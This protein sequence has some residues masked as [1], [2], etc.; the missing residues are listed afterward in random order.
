MSTEHSTG[1]PAVAVG[2]Y[3]AKESTQS[4]LVLNAEGDA[5]ATVFIRNL[6]ALS[7]GEGLDA[8]NERCRAAALAQAHLLA[9]SWDLLAAC[10]AC[11]EN[12]R[13]IH[14][15]LGEVPE[16]SPMPK[17]CTFEAWKMAAEAIARACGLHPCDDPA[18][19]TEVLQTQPQCI[20]GEKVTSAVLR[21]LAE[22]I[23]LRLRHLLP[24]PNNFG[25]SIVPATKLRRSS[26]VR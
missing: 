26:A 12:L 15:A 5:L 18:L 14:D 1:A 23:S 16:G 24:G 10:E 4:M 20:H 25:A 3:T 8:W 9:A 2:P 22:R 19:V 6:P 21:P 11:E 7:A 13:L 17:H